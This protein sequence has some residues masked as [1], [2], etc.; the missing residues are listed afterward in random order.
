MTFENMIPS[1]GTSDVD[2]AVAFYRSV[3]GF[4]AVRTFA[5]RDG[6]TWAHLKHGDIEL[7]FFRGRAPGAAETL[8]LFFRC[9]DVADLHER[10]S[11]SGLE[12][13]DLCLT[14]Y[15][16]L[17]FRMRDSEG[18]T[19]CFSQDCKAVRMTK[20]RLRE[21]MEAKRGE[22]LDTV[23]SLPPSRRETPGVQGLWS[24]K[25]ILAH[26]AAWNNRLLRWI[27][28]SEQGLT[29][30]TPEPDYAWERID[31]LN[32][33][34]YLKSKDAGYDEALESFN[35]SYAAI[36]ERLDGWRDEELNRVGMYDWCLGEP[37]W[38]MIGF[39]TFDHYRSHLA[40]IR[41]WLDQADH[42]AKPD[43]KEG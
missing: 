38:V 42:G 43:S 12:P 34:T 37:L 27:G 36:L 35:A 7:A 14:P 19:L 24:V 10:V 1:I 18:Y 30:E 25:D 23:G 6:T 40:A 32:H 21:Y 41:R 3:L 31:Q 28:E 15:Q 20:E 8:T 33:D 5:D 4:E 11:R 17:E 26:L 2:A 13:G 9:D 16:A 22:L 39:N 29:P